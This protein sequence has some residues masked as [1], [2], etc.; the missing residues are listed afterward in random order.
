MFKVSGVVRAGRQQ[1]HGRFGAAFRGQRPQG[2]QKYLAVLLN[3]THPAFLKQSG[4]Y[5]FHH[6]AAGEHVRDSAG[7]AQIVLQDHE[8]SLRVSDQ[9][10][11]NHCDVYVSGNFDAAHFAAVMLAGVDNASGHDA[12]FNDFALMVDIVEK[13]IQRRDPLR[14][15]ALNFFPFRRRDDSG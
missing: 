5:L 2:R 1:D 3:R 15:S 11:A 8:V 13:K 7:D 12:V 4:E 6:P 10:R 14:Q 9:V